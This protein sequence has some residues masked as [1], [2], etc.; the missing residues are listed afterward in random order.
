MKVILLHDVEGVGSRGQAVEVADGYARNFL[1]PRKRALKAGPSAMKLAAE[2]G[3]L[4]LR[5]EEKHRQQAAESAKRLEAVSLTI[6]VNANEEG[7]LFG[8]VTAGDIEAELAK[9]DLG[10]EI[11]KRD[12]LL[13]EPIK[14]VGRYAVDVRLFKDV[15]G[16]VEIWVVPRSSE[17]PEGAPSDD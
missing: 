5:K 10:F 12:I 17:E 3:R 1:I 15:K 16:S 4:N 11:D 13:E 9:Q 6:I 7:K 8:S 14:Q 2:L